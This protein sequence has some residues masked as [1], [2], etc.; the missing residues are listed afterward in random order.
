MK[1]LEI[2]NKIT[3]S[4]I[5][6]FGDKLASV[7]LYGSSLSARRLPN[8][9][10][11]II[12]L[13]ERESP[14]DLSFLRFERSKYDIE[15]DL[16]IIN[17]PDIHPD[18]FA[19]DTHGQFVIS[20]LQQ[21]HPIYGE[22]P[23]LNFFPK[24]SQRVTSVIQKAQYYYFR[25]KKLQAND[26]HPGN[27]QD[28]SF[29]RKKLILMLS[30]FWLVYSGKVDTLA[31]SEHLNHVIS[32]LTHKNPYSGEVNFLLNDSAS[33]NWGNIFSLYQKYYFAILD[34]L[35]PV[36]KI[37]TSFVGNIYL[38]FYNIDSNKLAII[39]SGCPSDYDEREMIYF[40][41]IRGYDVINF[42]YTATGKSKGIKFC[43]PQHD[44]I[45]IVNHYKKD[46]EQIFV[47][48]NSYGGY[49]AL[50]LDR[51][52]LSKITK[53][54]AI[55]PVVDFQQVQSIE[56]LPNYL[57][58]HQP[59]WYR[60]K[61]QQFSNFIQDFPQINDDYLDRATI[62]HGEFDEQIKLD[63]IK[64]FCQTSKANLK[65]LKSKHL[66]LNRMTR[67]NLSSLDELL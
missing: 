31:D 42:H 38:E 7:L 17:I 28:F 2:A 53:I 6:H 61:E 30:D 60:F 23:F 8:D 56:T 44:I 63:T 22:N 66:S 48:G 21:A 18:S 9:L 57:A 50:A 62:L 16:Q 10:D 1:N 37:T 20:F 36:P 47:I 45:D 58:T 64:N 11:I 15:I 55:S 25:A 40:L 29:H 54:I 12:I 14:E 3:K 46:Y 33:F 5:N 39:A 51:N 35:R 4:A 43:L 24:Y 27:Q 65:I 52:T 26:I 32:I 59:G 49:A 13:K 19:H 67:E 34:A 41:N